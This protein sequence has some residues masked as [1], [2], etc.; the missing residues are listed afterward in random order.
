MADFPMVSMVLS[1][2][3]Q[4][5]LRPDCGEW[6]VRAAPAQEPT[7]PGTP[8]VTEAHLPS[9]QSAAI[10]PFKTPAAL[11][12]PSHSSFEMGLASHV[13]V[14]DSRYQ[15]VEVLQQRVG[16]LSNCLEIPS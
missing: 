2:E 1:C 8:L 11:S 10:G 4:K 9:N 3:V 13:A 7:R 5:W 12:S 14:W 6:F 15:I 16:G